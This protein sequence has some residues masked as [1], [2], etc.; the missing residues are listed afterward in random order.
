MYRLQGIN[1][2]KRWLR[3]FNSLVNNYEEIIIK[4]LHFHFP[5]QALQKPV[6]KL[7]M[8]FCCCF[9]PMMMSN[10]SPICFLMSPSLIGVGLRLDFFMLVTQN[11][12]PAPQADSVNHRLDFRNSF[13]SI[14]SRDA[15]N[16]AA[17]SKFEWYKIA[18]FVITL[19]NCTFEI[20]DENLVWYSRITLKTGN[21]DLFGFDLS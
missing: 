21:I 7:P 19:Q 8:L 16:N 2:I 15:R 1:L 9:V 13:L 14:F 18:L 11:K 5:Q 12:A 17:G 4:N 3:W 6:Q 10:R 20:N